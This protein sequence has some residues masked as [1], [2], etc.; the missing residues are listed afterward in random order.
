M[1]KATI[2]RDECSD[3]QHGN[4]YQHQY[5]RKIKRATQSPGFSGAIRRIGVK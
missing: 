2:K 3:S 5:N 4:Q 1:P